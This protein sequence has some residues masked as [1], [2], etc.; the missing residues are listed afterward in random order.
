MEMERLWFV[1]V[2]RVCSSNSGRFTDIGVLP[3]EVSL[4]SSQPSH[5][6]A[7][8]PQGHARSPSVNVADSAVIAATTGTATEYNDRIMIHTISVTVGL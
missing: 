5:E 1:L 3:P 8:V 2:W 4:A 6:S 7:L